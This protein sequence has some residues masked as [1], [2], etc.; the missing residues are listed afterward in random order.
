M[1][2]SLLERLNPV[3]DDVRGCHSIPQ[4][5]QLELHELIR[6]ARNGIT[7]RD[8]TIRLLKLELEHEKKA[9]LG[10]WLYGCTVN[11]K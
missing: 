11:E 2:L 1:P 9:N 10:K 8:E 6:D 7:E 4:Y 3:A 5:G